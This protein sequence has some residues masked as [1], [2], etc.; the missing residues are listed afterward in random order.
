MWEDSNYCWVVLCK[1]HWFHVRQNFLFRHK[2]P[3]AE[4]DAVDPLPAL[5]EHFTV[6]C[7]ECRRTYTYKPKDVRRVERELP[8]SFKP[9]T[10]FQEECFNPEAPEDSDRKAE[11]SRQQEL[12]QEV[13]P[14]QERVQGETRQEEPLQKEP[15]RDEPPQ[16]GQARAKGA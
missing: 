5:P 16:E 3:L 11:Q 4:T 1:N 2:I 7:D 12:P 8:E 14:Q 15:P 10:L 6:R 9:H 13:R